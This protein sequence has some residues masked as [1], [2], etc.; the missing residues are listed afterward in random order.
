MRVGQYIYGSDGWSLVSGVDT[1]A[2]ALVMVFVSPDLPEIGFALESLRDRCPH[3]NIVGCTTGGEIL[4]DE[5][6]EGYITA[7]SVEFDRSHVHVHS[8]A[9]SDR[10]ESFN[11]GKRIAGA[12]DAP[13]L[14][15]ILVLSDGLDTNGVMLVRG[16]RE[17]LSS[18]VPVFG[19]LAADGADFVVTKV[20]GNGPWRSG[21]VTA[22]GFYGAKLMLRSAAASGWFETG[23]AMEITNSTSNIIYEIGGRPAHEM[24]LEQSG[25]DAAAG[26]D[27]FMTRPLWI[28]ERGKADGGS[29]RGIIGIDDKRGSLVLA[30]EIPTNAVCKMM[31]GNAQELVA[32]AGR[33]AGELGRVPSGCLSIVVSC[34]GRKLMLGSERAEELRAISQVLSAKHQS[35]FYAYGEIGRRIST[36]HNDFLNHSVSLTAIWETG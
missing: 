3:A 16:L 36:A 31:E 33:A 19:G 2:P 9:L 8:C 21:Q 18:D 35:G 29:V 24:L 25:F 27:R 26:L 17:G 14:R 22:V 10:R 7:T 23:E 6:L 20:A 5:A 13:D 11:A 30:G 15:G 32:A 28:A 4:G 34:L 12:L 1:D